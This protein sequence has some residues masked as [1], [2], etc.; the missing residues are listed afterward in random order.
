MRD[1][2]DPKVEKR[3]AKAVLSSGLLTAADIDRARDVQRAAAKRGLSLPLDRVLLKLD[4]LTRDQILGLWRALR[5]Y[6]WRKEDK[7]WVK[8]A[9][10]SKILTEKT[11]RICLKEQKQAYKHEDQLIRVNEVA[12]QRG[13][14]TASQDRAIV[15]AMVQVRPVTLRPVDEEAVDGKG[16]ERPSAR[17]ARVGHEEEW[18]SAARNKDLKALRAHF[19]SSIEG[20]GVSDEDLDALWDEADLDDVELDS[21]AVE[22]AK[23]P[24]FDDS[25]IDL[26]DLE[27]DI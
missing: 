16:Y 12:R 5:Y 7:F 6:L 13:Y 19:D 4:M 21:Q 1:G 2:V 15:E 8:I 20:Q 22:I 27:F 23:G 17:A 25:D 14:V 24:M 3:F 18:K 10:Q 26:D 9:I 11:A